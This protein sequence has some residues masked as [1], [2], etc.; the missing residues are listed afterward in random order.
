MVTP[1]KIATARIALNFDAPFIL[2]TLSPHFRMPDPMNRKFYPVFL[3]LLV[4]LMIL[5]EIYGAPQSPN[6][7]EMFG[8]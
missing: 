1:A 7:W 4:T 6:V 3:A 2:L 5:R 8:W